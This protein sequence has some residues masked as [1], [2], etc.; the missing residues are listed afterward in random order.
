MSFDRYLEAFDDDTGG[1]EHAALAVYYLG[2]VEAQPRVT[3]AEVRTEIERSRSTYSPTGVSR[4]FD[5]LDKDGLI[6]SVGDGGYRL[7]PDGISYVEERLDDAELVNTRGEDDLFIDATGFED[8]GKYNQLVD[9]IN[10]CYRYRIYDATLVLS[11]KLF[12][13]LVF[14]ILKTHYSRDD[15]QMFYDHENERHYN[16]DELLN[17][18]SDAVPTLKRYSREL[19]RALVEGVR[20]LKNEGNAGAHAIRVDFTDDEVDALSGEAT[21]YAEILYDILQGVRIAERDE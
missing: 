11:R 4:Y 13:D 3:Q 18:L 7:T 14:Q 6:A 20:E 5:R 9:D 15:V 10:E 17:N 1:K 21:R 2:E 8:D 19:D 12:E 16:F